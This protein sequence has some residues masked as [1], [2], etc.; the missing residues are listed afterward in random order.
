MLLM[1][2]HFRFLVF[3]KFRFLSILVSKVLDHLK[4]LVLLDL[5]LKYYIQSGVLQT[6]ANMVGANDFDSF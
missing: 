3:A 4:Y 5:N 6:V 1:T 2:F